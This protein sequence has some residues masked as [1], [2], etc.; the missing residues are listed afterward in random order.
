[1]GNFFAGSFLSVSFNDPKRCITWKADMLQNLLK[2]TGF[3][4]YSHHCIFNLHRILNKGWLAS[5]EGGKVSQQKLF[6]HTCLPYQARILQ[7][8]SYV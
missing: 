1:M 7:L 2:A 8:V 6:H 5:L 3:N 4:L